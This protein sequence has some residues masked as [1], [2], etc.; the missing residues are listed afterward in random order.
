MSNP[1][2]ELDDKIHMLLD[3]VMSLKDQVRINR[4]SI[5]GLVATQAP[6]PEQHPYNTEFFLT[7]A[8]LSQLLGPTTLSSSLKEKIWAEQQIR[9]A[10]EE[11]SS[12]RDTQDMTEDQHEGY[13]SAI[14]GRRNEMVVEDALL[15]HNNRPHWLLQARGCTEDEDSR[16]IDV[17]VTTDVGEVYLQVKSSY[18]N[19]QKFRRKSRAAVVGVVV[20]RPT[21]SKDDIFNKAFDAVAKRRSEINKACRD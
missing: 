13:H 21:D 17:V 1:G 19:A 2:K 6:E 12:S 8:E 9:A 20:V 11:V 5:Q 4:E 16:G 18:S 14:R 15:T 7:D 3:S 10:V